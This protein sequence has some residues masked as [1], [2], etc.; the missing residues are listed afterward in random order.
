MTTD[1]NE[2]PTALQDE[3]WGDQTDW[4]A[5]TPRPQ[6]GVPA[7]RPSRLGDA[8]GRIW[9]AL[10]GGGDQRERVHG[11]PTR[12]AEFVV[13]PPEPAI[14]PGEI[15]DADSAW[16]IEPEPR[17]VRGAGVDPL[18]ARFGALAVIVTLAVP[19]VLGFTSDRDPEPPV[20]RT[21]DMAAVSADQAIPASPSD[22]PTAETPAEIPTPSVPAQQEATAGG[23]EQPSA[24]PMAA[25]ASSDAAQSNAAT[26]TTAT[27]NS[28]APCGSRY[29]L[30]AGDYWI[31][32]AD[33]ADVSL[34]DLLEVNDASVETVLVPGRSICLPV[35]A[36]TP[37]PPST[38]APTTSPAAAA[39]AAPRT[40]TA[41]RVTSTTAAPTTT[42]PARPPAVSTEQAVA[43]IRS[44]WPDDLEERALEI[45]WRESKY[46]SNVNNWC[47]YGL[48]QIHWNAHR[49]WL[50]SLGI[51][52]ASQLYDPTVNATAAYVLYQRAGGFGPWGG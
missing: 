37:A 36:T 28:S 29:E 1:R 20:L 27:P 30:A 23:S 7:H 48:F 13:P 11:S 24:A 33:A 19:V 21:D 41:P 40:T 9:G 47:C 16:E 35:G 6:G 49:S 18:L 5:E 10:V 17:P 12:D 44:V 46:Q 26:P 38:A 52:S 39:V 51:T 45:A 31:R 22:A 8:A 43:V 14:E 34:A 4:S 3:F 32:I 50:G 25:A 42:V 2:P 15:D